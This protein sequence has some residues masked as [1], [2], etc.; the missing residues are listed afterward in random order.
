LLFLASGL[1]SSE[2]LELILRSESESGCEVRIGAWMKFLVEKKSG[3]S[4]LT[5]RVDHKF[6]S[7][8]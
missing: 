6:I 7:F 5:R 1:S 8:A 4:S 2:S 3:M